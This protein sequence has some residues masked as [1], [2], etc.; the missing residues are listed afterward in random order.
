MSYLIKTKLHAYHPK[1]IRLTYTKFHLIASPQSEVRTSQ[2]QTMNST[3]E[4]VRSA[5]KF[6][7]LQGKSSGIIHGELKNT[8]PTNVPSLSTV[9]Y[10]CRRFGSGVSSVL[11][12]FKSGRNKSAQNETNVENIRKILEQ[13]RRLSIREIAQKSHTS[14][15]TAW[16]IVTKG[17]GLILRCARWVPK[18]LSSEQMDA[19][20]SAS[21]ENIWLN[22]LD[23]E[24]FKNQI[25]TG[26]ETYLHHYEPESKRQSMQ[27]LPRGSQAPI[28]AIRKVSSKKVMALIFW[29][30]AGVLLVRYFR[31]GAT[32]TGYIYSKVMDQLRKAIQKKRPGKWEDGIFLIHDNASSHTSAVAQEAIR[33]N[34]FIQLTHPPY[35]PDLAPSDFHLFPKLK[36]FLRKR[37]FNSDDQLQKCTNNWLE[38]QPT[39]FY[40]QGINDLEHRWEKCVNLKGSYVEK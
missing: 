24:F 35:S 10:W 13:D 8:L 38:R 17:L 33:R 28:K 15:T 26:D 12:K 20:K 7:Y 16:R 25:V 37:T 29:D 6:L 9:K 30:N 40:N 23:P 36:N 5:I 18:L 39:S 4:E 1:M 27:W 2:N 19:R 14:I 11:D 34:E 31:K 32:L 21:E 22:S 3:K